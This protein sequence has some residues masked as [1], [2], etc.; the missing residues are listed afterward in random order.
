[1]SLAK[2]YR[3]RWSA[4]LVADAAYRAGVEVRVAPSPIRP[5][6]PSWR[7]VGPVRTVQADNDLVA[8][9]AAVHRASS[10]D[11]IVVGNPTREVGLA[12]DLILT[13]AAR[14]GLGGLVVD[15]MVRDRSELLEIGVPVFSRGTVPVGPLKLPADLKGRGRLDVPVSLGDIRVEP[16]WWAF[17]DADGI[18]FVP[19]GHAAAIETEAAAAEE[20]EEALTAALR[21]GG[22]LGD[23]LALDEFLAERREN[24]DADFNAHLRRIGRAI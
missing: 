8:V 17:G 13:E 12:G 19:D 15:A 21:A 9:L 11:V 6:D 1:M 16:G 3:E 2:L 23:L 14:K 20:R 4:A 5:L 22:S 7:L 18:V 10:G 24:P